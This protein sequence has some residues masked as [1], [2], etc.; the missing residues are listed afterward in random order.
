MQGRQSDVVNSTAEDTVIIAVDHEDL[1]RYSM[2]KQHNQSTDANKN[3]RASLLMGYPIYGD[4]LLAAVGGDWRSM[5]LYSKD[6]SLSFYY[7]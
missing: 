6:V 4:V 2:K 1:R 3:V 5:K 7:R